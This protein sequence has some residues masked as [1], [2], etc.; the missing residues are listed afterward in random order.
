[1]ARQEA[2]DAAP[3]PSSSGETEPH[4]AAARMVALIIPDAQ[5]RSTRDSIPN[6]C[7]MLSISRGIFL[8]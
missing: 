3:T 8:V 2:A 1:V 6:R 4:F 7:R 5:T